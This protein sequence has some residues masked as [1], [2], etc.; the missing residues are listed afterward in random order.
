MDDYTHFLCATDQQYFEL[1]DRFE[2]LGLSRI[3]LAAGYPKF[4]RII[5]RIQSTP[6]NHTS[7]SSVL[8]VLLAPS[9]ASE[10]VYS[11]VS[12]LPWIGEIV[13][14]LLEEGHKVIFRPHPVSLRRG[15]F[16]ESI[17][18]V[19]DK[20]ASTGRFQ[21]DDSQDYFDTYCSAHV[22]V[23]DVSGT[24]MMFRLAFDKPVFFFTPD[25]QMAVRAFQSIPQL[26]SVTS[27]LNDLLHVLSA[28]DEHG[29]LENA[30]EVFN[31]GTSVDFFVNTLK[32]NHD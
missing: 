31:Q 11:D 3:V 30:P 4:D 27:D 32:C 7:S 16:I 23:T 6:S 12:F 18:A 26:G 15:S 20:Y 14:A 19:R 29:I 2:K 1:K 28:Q 25:P 17:E 21:F 10:D 8:T 22:M 24:S 5:N 13:G 9:Y